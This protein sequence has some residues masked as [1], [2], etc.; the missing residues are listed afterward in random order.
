[1]INIDTYKRLNLNKMNIFAGKMQTVAFLFRQTLLI[2][3]VLFFSGTNIYSS[4][5]KD[6]VLNVIPYPQQVRLGGDDFNFS[7]ELTIVIENNHSEA[8]RFAAEELVDDLKKEWGIDAKVATQKGRKSIVLS[9]THASASLKEQGYRITTLGN[10]LLISAK[11]EAGLFYGTQ[12]FLQLIKKVREGFQVPGM[13]INDWPDIK[14]RAAHY[15]T[16]HHQDKRSYV[17]SFIKDLAK[18]KMNQLVW[19]WEDKLAYEKHPEIGA[20][21]AFTIT[22]MQEITRYAKKY[23]VELIPLVQGLGHVSFILKWPQYKHLRE[24]ADSNWEFCPLKEGTY[25]L[26]FDLWEEA[27]E[28]TPGSEYIHIGSDE[29]Y[30]LAACEHCQARAKE[31]GKSGVY[32]LFVKRAAEHLQKL[33]RKV[34]VW[35]RP[36][37]WKQNSSPVKNFDLAKGL[38]LTESYNYG[39]SNFEYVKESKELGYEVYAYDP[40]PGIE[41]LFLP[42]KFKLKAGNKTTG[43]LEN[44]YQFLTSAAMSGAFDGMINTS[45]DDSGLHNQMWMLSFVT[46]AEYSWSG[47]KPTLEEFEHS[48][49]KNYYGSSAMD[50]EELY[51]LL[52]EGAYYYAWTLERNVW[53]HGTIG[54]THLPDIPR[55]DNIEYDP[56]WNKEYWEKIQE[57]RQMLDKMKR[58]LSIIENNKNA[59]VKNVYDFELYRTL[60]KLIEHTCL[61]YIDLSELENTITRAHSL[62]FIDKQQAYQHLEQAQELIETS[63]NRREKVYNDLVETWEQT[64][65][66]KGMSTPDKE[67]FFQQDRAR[68]FA[69]R[70]ADMSYLI[71]DEELLDM[72]GYLER[73]KKYM[74]YYKEE[75]GA[76]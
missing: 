56:Y 37:G 54:K 38:V 27:I 23:H 24:I 51:C 41:P 6:L 70:T 67:F 17:E 4:E 1:M 40:N 21:G 19:E 59:G 71:Y 63:I 26:L 68:H 69:F 32:H 8:D 30:E 14:K 18:Y 52:N 35:E 43:S 74:R 9:R 72:E 57:S 48:F 42:Y 13:E 75:V 10:E 44:S 33:N 46:S 12:T 66:P 58:A 53:H 22:E 2:L 64:R 61:T 76:F 28:A 55:N 36:M 25:D 20:P 7:E 60:A 3:L 73:F 31:I 16:K 34:M 29:T 39:T 45:W 11:S 65:L 15:D 49:Y 5:L 50:L 62:T 47:S